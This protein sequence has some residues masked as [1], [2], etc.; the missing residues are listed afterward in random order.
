MVLRREGDGIPEEVEEDSDGE[1]K[2]HD[3]Y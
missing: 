2:S 1:V 3:G